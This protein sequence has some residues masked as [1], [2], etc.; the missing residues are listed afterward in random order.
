M[1]RI[2]DAAILN[3]QIQLGNALMPALSDFPITK[4]W[5]A[6]H[7]DRLQGFKPIGVAATSGDK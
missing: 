3:N 4:R 5:P 6:Q 1:H 7:P 2:S